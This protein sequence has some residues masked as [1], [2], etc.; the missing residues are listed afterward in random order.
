[1][2]E[3]PLPSSVA[4]SGGSV[5]GKGAQPRASARGARESED[6][7]YCIAPA[8]CDLYFAISH[9]SGAAPPHHTTRSAP[10]SPPPPLMFY[11]SKPSNAAS[12]ARSSSVSRHDKL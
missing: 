3:A 10:L 11:V 2:D 7:L 8:R 1:M 9:Y 5:Q 6:T 4:T 12:C